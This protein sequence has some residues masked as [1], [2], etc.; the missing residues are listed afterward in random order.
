MSIYHIIYKTTHVNGK[1]YIGRHTTKNKND[2][3][4][5]SGKWVQSIKDKSHLSKEILAE[6]SSIEELYELEE[7]YISK[8][9]DDPLC[10]NYNRGSC[11]WNAL[12]ITEFNKQIQENGKSRSY[13]RAKNLYETKRSG[14]ITQEGINIVYKKTEDGTNPFFRREDGTSVAS[15]SVKNGTHNLVGGVTC[16][17]KDGSIHQIKKEEYYDQKGDMVYWEYVSIASD[18]G[19]IRMGKPINKIVCINIFGETTKLTIKKF[20]CL[21]NDYWVDINSNEG[22]RRQNFPES[23]ENK[24][25]YYNLL[26]KQSLMLKYGVDNV[27]KIPETKIKVKETNNKKYGVDHFSKSKEGKEKIKQ[28]RKNDPVFEC[29]ICGK[30]IKG[31]NNIKSHTKTHEKS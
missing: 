1:Y 6:A 3:Y 12:D 7:Y 13:N 27:S 25:K 26:A 2:K 15:D 23:L 14:L 8:H 11:G 28:T 24:Q 9:Y 5:G 4:F 16:V 17:D 30:Q 18:E 31:I 20:N 19:K 10:M 22:N 29:E 21:K